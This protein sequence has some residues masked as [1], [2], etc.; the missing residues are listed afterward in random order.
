MTSK[1]VYYLHLVDVAH[2]VQMPGKCEDFTHEARIFAG[3]SLD[4]V[5]SRAGT[6]SRESLR[7]QVRSLE[8]LLQKEPD[9]AFPLR[10]TD[11]LETTRNVIQQLETEV[12]KEVRTIFRI[13]LDRITNKLAGNDTNG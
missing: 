6:V 13:E 12:K 1:G 2:P 4:L 10:I 9:E 5:R 11:K 8:Y 3:Y 7:T